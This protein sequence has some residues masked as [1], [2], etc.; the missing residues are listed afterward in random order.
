M[1]HQ[2]RF[3]AELGIVYIKF[4]GSQNVETIFKGFSEAILIAE[5]IDAFRVVSDFRAATLQLSTLQIYSLPDALSACKPDSSPWL[6]KYR[7][8]VVANIDDDYRFMVTMLNNRSQNAELFESVSDAE[9]WLKATG[10]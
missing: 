10:K 2:L 9:S 8:A 7:H 4:E 3:D 1:S 5:S 6:H